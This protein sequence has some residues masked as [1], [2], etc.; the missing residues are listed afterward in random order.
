MHFERGSH[1]NYCRDFSM[2]NLN[3]LTSFYDF[4]KLNNLRSL[5]ST[6][7][8]WYTSISGTIGDT[9]ILL[10]QTP[11]HTIIWSLH[12]LLSE[13]VVWFKSGAVLMKVGK[14]LWISSIFFMSDFR[15]TVL[16]INPGSKRLR[17]SY[18][19]LIHIL[20]RFKN[21]QAKLTR[22]FGCQWRENSMTSW[23]IK[24]WM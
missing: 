21:P 17:T 11:H 18:P 12:R 19:N 8:N 1:S 22:L 2:V 13:S 5:H 10:L 4:L 20:H 15:C 14:I 16:L 7:M 23:M 9:Y 3:S 6:S 24:W